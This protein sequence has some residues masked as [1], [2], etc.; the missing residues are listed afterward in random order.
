MI[1][2]YKEFLTIVKELEDKNIQYALCGGFAVS[3]H[4]FVRATEDIDFIVMIETLGEIR[5]ILIK[6]NYLIEASP[7]TL[8]DGKIK[9]YR[10]TKIDKESGDY[11]PIDLLVLNSELQY[12][13]GK[14][15]KFEL[16]NC[17]VKVLS[18]EALIELKLLRNSYQDKQDIE[19]LNGYSN[20][21]S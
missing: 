2:I 19:K 14:I 4:W 5:N 11:L 10:L 1:D 13:W 15:E 7:M 17:F 12:I 9:I 18:K 8:S 21:Q 16:E 3:L 6:M 20:E